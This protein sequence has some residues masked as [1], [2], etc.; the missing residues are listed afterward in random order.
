MLDR[1]RPES[2]ARP[3]ART[4]VT[5]RRLCELSAYLLDRHRFADLPRSQ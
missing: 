4:P 5:G 2:P 1:L 3:V